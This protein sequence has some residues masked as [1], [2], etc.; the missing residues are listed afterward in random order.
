MPLWASVL[1]HLPPSVSNGLSQSVSPAAFSS[2]SLLDK[3]HPGAAFFVYYYK[4][5]HWWCARL[6]HSHYWAHIMQLGTLH[7]LRHFTLT[8]FQSV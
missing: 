2:P 8:I 6:L 1:R 5:L 7:D 3:C 4:K